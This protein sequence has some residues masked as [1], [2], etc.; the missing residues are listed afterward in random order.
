MTKKDISLSL[1]CN[2]VNMVKEELFYWRSSSCSFYEK[3]CSSEIDVFAKNW[4]DGLKSNHFRGCFTNF[5][6]LPLVL[7]SSEFLIDTDNEKFTNS[8]H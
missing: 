1:I 3:I 5:I 6:K 8:I 2:E 4:R 7:K